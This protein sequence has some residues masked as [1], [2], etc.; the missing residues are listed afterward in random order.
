MNLSSIKNRLTQRFFPLKE[1]QPDQAYDLWAKEYD[2]QPGNL[3]LDLDETLFSELIRGVAFRNKRIIDFGCGTGRHWQKLY[4]EHPAQLHGYDVS[5]GMLHV[6]KKKFPQAKVSLL[7]KTKLSECPGES[8]DILVSS[9]TIAHVENIREA[10]SE[11]NRALKPGAQILITD[12]HPDTLA[13]GGNRTFIHEG[14]KVAIKNHV[15][16]LPV[17]RALANEL[18]W[19]EDFFKEYVIDETVKHYYAR[20]KALHV[21]ER[22]KGTPIIY[23]IRFRKAGA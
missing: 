14:K 4:A 18:R 12:Y 10:F 7:L 5:Q 21:Y 2:A 6:L 1:T 15:H 3:M 13:K 17:I 8:E 23:G 16:T 11:W 9:L 22:F 20:Q 19:E